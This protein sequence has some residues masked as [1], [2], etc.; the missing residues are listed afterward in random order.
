MKQA[1]IA[2]EASARITTKRHYTILVFLQKLIR[3]RVLGQDVVAVAV[4]GLERHFRA[5]TECTCK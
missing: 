4:S 1:A 2:D 5:T 3:V